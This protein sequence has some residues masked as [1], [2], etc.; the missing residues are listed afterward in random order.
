MSGELA[1]LAGQVCPVA[2]PELLSFMRPVVVAQLDTQ[3]AQPEVQVLVETVEAHPY[4]Q[5]EQL[6]LALVVV[7]H[8]SH[9]HELEDSERPEL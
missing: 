8:L 9:L 1:V 5:T 7:V 6:I 2:S 4:Q 3:A